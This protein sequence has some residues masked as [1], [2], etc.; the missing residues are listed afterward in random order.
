M[1]SVIQ[2]PPVLPKPQDKPT[3]AEAL[4]RY[5]GEL[6]EELFASRG[7]VEIALPLL[8][9]SIAGVSGRYTNGRFYKGSLTKQSSLS[10]EKLSGYQMGLE[11]FNNNLHDFILEKEKLKQSKQEEAKEKKAPLYNPFLEEQE[12]ED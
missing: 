2:E 11:D 9:E 5:N 7:W 3:S 4:I 8:K 10:L 6:V 1:R 12:L